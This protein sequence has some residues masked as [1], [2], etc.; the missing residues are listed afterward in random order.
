MIDIVS[1]FQTRDIV[2]ILERE[3]MIGSAPGYLKFQALVFDL[4]KDLQEALTKQDQ[5]NE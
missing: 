3:Q 4:K 5:S 1:G 2:S